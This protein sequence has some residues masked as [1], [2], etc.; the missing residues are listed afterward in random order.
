[1]DLPFPELRNLGELA[2]A[3]G[4]VSMWQKERAARQLLQPGFL[5]K[6]L[7]IFHVRVVQWC[8]GLLGSHTCA[9]TCRHLAAVQA[10]HITPRSS[11]VGGPCGSAC[12]QGSSLCTATQRRKGSEQADEG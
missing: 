10:A 9:S 6:L 12:P 11:C 4:G 1:M 8:K 5:D 2:T 7:E 3:L